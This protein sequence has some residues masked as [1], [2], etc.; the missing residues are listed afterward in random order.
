MLPCSDPRLENQC[1][2]RTGKLRYAATSSSPHL[3]LTECLPTQMF[4]PE[5]GLEEKWDRKVTES[6]DIT[7][8]NRRN[9]RALLLQ[10]GFIASWHNHR[11]YPGSQP[12]LFSLLPLRY[13]AGSFVDASQQLSVFWF[14]TFSATSHK[15]R[16]GAN[17][18]GRGTR[19]LVM[20]N[21][22]SRRQCYSK[23]GQRTITDEGLKRSEESAKKKKSPEPASE[24]AAG[25]LLLWRL[26]PFPSRALQAFSAK[27]RLAMRHRNPFELQIRCQLQS[28]QELC[29]YKSTSQ[30]VS[31][32]GRVRTGDLL[33]VRQ[34]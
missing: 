10:G 15:R 33:R 24:A 29:W 28:Q 20:I 9:S 13:R 22:Q 5:E 21:T 18:E 23:N 32:A 2:L 12:I 7:Q 4:K 30:L 17:R 25:I 27:A 11:R 19:A 31:E 1:G 8:R 6:G 26:A 34:T 16:R 3:I 14:D